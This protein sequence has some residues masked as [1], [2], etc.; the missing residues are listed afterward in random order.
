MLV[1]YAIISVAELRTFGLSGSDSL[2]EMLINQATDYIER[3]CQRR[4]ADTSYSAQLYDGDGSRNIFLKN[5]PVISLTSLEEN[6][7]YNNT[8]N[9][10]TLVTDDYF[11][12]NS[13]GIIERVCAFRKGNQNYRITYRA[14]YAASDMPYDL[15]YVCMMLCSEAN[16]QRESAGIKSETLGDHSITF[17]STVQ[18][19]PR[20]MDI[21]KM[22]RRPNMAPAC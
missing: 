2:L 17:E 6:G 15:K 21:L 9:W 20:V 13:S 16:T 1:S 19:N 7:S 11:V 3:Y 10:S 18:S 14:G 12:E 5:F 22:Y 8:S 4:F